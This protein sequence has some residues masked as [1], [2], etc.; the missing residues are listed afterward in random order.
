MARRLIGRSRRRAAAWVAVVTAVT[1]AHVL[2]TQRLARS[3]ADVT[4]AGAMP[5]RIEV[6]FVREL[7]PAEPPVPPAPPS[8]VKRPKARVR[9]ALPA[10]APAEPERE[11]EP[12]QEKQPQP[13]PSVPVGPDTESGPPAEAHADAS[14]PTPKPEPKPAQLADAEPAQTAASAASVA[15]E[16]F[17]WPPSTQL[18]YALHGY[19]RGDLEGTAQV[20][21]VRAGSRY[22]VHL[23][24]S[25][26]LLFS[27]RMTSDGELTD[28]G[29]RPGRYD[30]ETRVG[31]LE[32]RRLEMRFEPGHVVLAGG[33]RTAA[34]PGVQDTASQ[35]VQLTWMFIM[36][37]H[38]LREGSA[39]ELPLALPRRVK[40][41]VFDV[42]GQERLD[43]PVG[44]LDT[45]HLV[46][47]ADLRPGNDLSAQVWVA[48]SLQYLPVRIRIHQDAETYVD[49]SIRALPLQARPAANEPVSPGVPR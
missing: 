10:S 43:T 36:R 39:I 7:A 6:A 30:E 21:W 44:P 33:T 5:P 1:L 35:F 29:L 18:S 47:R 16:S 46:P 37:P 45:F 26:A 25:A 11:H 23:D 41:V 13:E 3:L 28:E 40:R 8:I 17:E 27:R 34:P 9:P 2:V 42:V 20:Q 15:G 32:P 38:L 31:W 4:G 14:A 48:P 24:V 12:E 19:Y 49:L 22:Q